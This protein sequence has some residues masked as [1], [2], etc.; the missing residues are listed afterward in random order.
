MFC[1]SV[2]HAKGGIDL[3]LKAREKIG[4]WL[5]LKQWSGERWPLHEVMDGA[6][7]LIH[8]CSFHLHLYPLARSSVVH[9]STK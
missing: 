3:T 6:V 1:L 9:T 4:N 7:E 8:I 5:D 2:A